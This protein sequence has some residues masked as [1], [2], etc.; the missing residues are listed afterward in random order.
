MLNN[1]NYKHLLIPI[2]FCFL[3]LKVLMSYLRFLQIQFLIAFL[4]YLHNGTRHSNYEFSFKEFSFSWEIE[5]LSWIQ[6]FLFFPF[7]YFVNIVR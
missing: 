5:L 4:I 1:Q 7:N 2:L 3:F 6:D